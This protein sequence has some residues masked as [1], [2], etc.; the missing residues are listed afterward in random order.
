MT[1]TNA[2]ALRNNLFGMLSNA[3]RYN[4]TIN[5]N[6]KEG[7]AVIISE[8]E[9]NG[10]MATLELSTDKKLRDKILSGKETPLD[11]CVSID[12]VKW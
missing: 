2:T 6:T 9:Y 12:E 4:E 1:N 3:I 11:E 8:E 5:V 10:M 7:N